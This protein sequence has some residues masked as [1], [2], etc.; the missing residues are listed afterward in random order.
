[1]FKLHV[2]IVRYFH[3]IEGPCLDKSYKL[4]SHEFTKM[5]SNKSQNFNKPTASSSAKKWEKRTMDNGS[6]KKIC[7]NYSTKINQ[8]AGISKPE[9]GVKKDFPNV[10]SKII[11]QTA[12]S[13]INV[14]SLATVKS[15]INKEKAEDKVPYKQ[16]WTVKE[17]AQKI[18]K[19]ME[20]GQQLANQTGKPILI[21]K[22]YR[23]KEKR[24]I[25]G[26]LR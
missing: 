8:N 12:K 15:T 4:Y 1:M 20:E 2:S 24:K 3:D 7:W 13:E 22:K 9:P 6:I 18:E 14:K 26:K 5:T 19:K 25:G 16:R 10:K 21:K 11:S 23:T 17:L